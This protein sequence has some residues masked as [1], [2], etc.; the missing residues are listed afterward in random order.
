MP[1][2]TALSFSLKGIPTWQ[3]FFLVLLFKSFCYLFRD[4][5]MQYFFFWL[6]YRKAIWQICWSFCASVSN[7]RRVEQ[8][9]LLFLCVW[10]FV[11]AMINSEIC[12]LR[13]HSSTEVQAGCGTSRKSCSKEISIRNLEELL[14]CV[15]RWK[16]AL[17]YSACYGEM[18]L[19][20]DAT[21]RDSL[22]TKM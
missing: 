22:H 21:S 10:K 19:F 6:Q 3:A 2:N 14:R 12:D 17:L 7:F 13:S 11:C 20:F 1:N 4:C 18:V 9:F 15:L 8:N 16:Q 5:L